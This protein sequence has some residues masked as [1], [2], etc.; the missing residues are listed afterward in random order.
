MSTEF[1]NIES[2]QPWKSEGSEEEIP[3]PKLPDGLEASFKSFHRDLSSIEREQ[4]FSIVYTDKNKNQMDLCIQ[5]GRETPLFKKIIKERT[6]NPEGV[7]N[8]LSK[9]I[10]SLLSASTLTQKKF[11]GISIKYERGKVSSV[12]SGNRE[13]KGKRFSNAQNKHY[14]LRARLDY[15]SSE[16][17][18]EHLFEKVKPGKKK[19]H[20]FE[21]STIRRKIAKI[22]ILS[23]DAA[24]IS[25]K[26]TD[27]YLQQLRKLQKSPMQGIERKQISRKVREIERKALKHIQRS[28]VDIPKEQTSERD[29]ENQ[30]IIHQNPLQAQKKQTIKRQQI[31]KQSQDFIKRYRDLPNKIDLFLKNSKAQGHFLGEYKKLEQEKDQLLQKLSEFTDVESTQFRDA[32]KSLFPISSQEIQAQLANLPPPENSEETILLQLQREAEKFLLDVEETM[33][34]MVENYR[35]HP[36]ESEFQNLMDLRNFLESRRNDLLPK[37]QQQL[38][39]YVQI[40]KQAPKHLA[41]TLQNVV[42]SQLPDAVTFFNFLNEI[43]QRPIENIPQQIENPLLQIDQMRSDH[44]QI[45]R[46][47]Q[48]KLDALQ[49]G[50]PLNMIEIQNLQN[51]L[52]AIKELERL[53][54]EELDKL[55]H[56]QIVN[57]QN[58]EFDPSNF[59]NQEERMQLEELRKSILYTDS[60][61]QGIFENHQ[62]MYER[63]QGLLQR[64]NDAQ[65]GAIYGPM[66]GEFEKFLYDFPLEFAQVNQL[67]LSEQ[68]IDLNLVGPLIG[69]LEDAIQRQQQLL[70]QIPERSFLAR[71]GNL[72]R[73]QAKKE[74]FEQAILQVHDLVSRFEIL[75]S[76][77]EEVALPQVD[78]QTAQAAEDLMQR[79][80]GTQKV[81][82]PHAQKLQDEVAEILKI[83]LEQART[84]APKKMGELNQLV[85]Y[86]REA[87]RWL[88]HYGK[89]PFIENP[90]FKTQLQDRWL[91]LSPS[92]GAERVKRMSGKEAFKAIELYY[93]GIKATL[94]QTLQTFQNI[95]EIR[96]P[97]PS[98]EFCQVETSKLAC[99]SYGPRIPTQALEQA[100]FTHGSNP[101]KAI[102]QDV[103][104]TIGNVYPESRE[105]AGQN[106]C[107]YL[108]FALGYIASISKNQKALEQLIRFAANLS[109]GGPI[110]QLL[111]NHLQQL[112]QGNP[113]YDLE[114]V[115]FSDDHANDLVKIF[116]AIA[117]QYIEESFEK[118]LY[119]NHVVERKEV[120]ALDEN[121]K[122]MVGRMDVQYN[123]KLIP[124]RLNPN[125][126]KMLPTEEMYRD[127]KQEI[128]RDFYQVN[129]EQEFY[130]KYY[131]VNSEE[132]FIQTYPDVDSE[133]L[134]RN[135]YGKDPG[136]RL[137][138]L[139]MLRVCRENGLNLKER[140]QIIAT[141]GERPIESIE[142][143]ALSKIFNHKFLDI[144]MMDAIRMQ[145]PLAF[146][147]NNLLGEECVIKAYP[148]PEVQGGG[149]PTYRIKDLKN[150]NLFGYEGSFALFAKSTGHSEVVFKNP[151]RQ[152]V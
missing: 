48:E 70:P 123:Y 12:S 131:N 1:S 30:V 148:I 44:E 15:L 3:I 69:S 22:E 53:C 43:L 88:E 141:P 28:F 59:A 103:F 80:D 42:E 139:A 60:S 92:L 145:E 118:D 120:P 116:R 151:T 23:K 105:T 122:P 67:M 27:K 35:K 11:K 55:D 65:D 17:K 75:Q 64:Q 87:E 101:R 79:L 14:S 91:A 115:A 143:E 73:V 16:E 2:S 133:A 137:N 93:K 38:N 41:Q 147:K 113:G 21:P 6:K 62:K 95:Q 125:C 109:S 74:Q 13:I 72:E 56:E 86:Y 119:G 90:A 78:P 128:L 129:S 4:E 24:K 5:I 114:G 134:F 66:L 50:V 45:E 57:L 77:Q 146:G 19:Q 51:R 107:A 20:H 34:K 32:I 49:S 124:G 132:E 47:I 39:T 138:Y 25:E 97:F 126:T 142:L 40:E 8:L 82:N 85:E 150:G 36:S 37:L 63:V 7:R 121:D 9:H 10:S 94:E 18:I 149:I 89:L 61:L 76:K 108:S 83:D 98:Q 152:M 112:Y 68:D 46:Q 135:Q 104:K 102:L 106:N 130:L 29:E 110:H 136:T 99:N 127:R 117:A 31:L 96:H 58:A 52:N 71:I 100:V 26:R 33:T 140:C 84:L 81:W 111:N 54:T 144:F